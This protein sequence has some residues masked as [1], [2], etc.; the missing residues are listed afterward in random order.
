MTYSLDTVKGIKSSNVCEYWHM[1]NL[2]LFK[3]PSS[4]REMCATRG[5]SITSST[6][7]TS[8][9]SSTW[10]PKHTLVRSSCSTSA[11]TPLTNLVW[12]GRVKHTSA[13]L[14]CS[15]SSFESPSAFQ[16]VN[17][18][19]TRV[20]LQA[21]HGA[22][23]Q[24]Q[25]FVYV[26]TDEV[27]GGSVEEA[28]GWPVP[29]WNARSLARWITGSF[30]VLQVFDESSPVRPSNPYSATKAAAEYLV[31]SYWDKYKVRLSCS[32]SSCSLLWLSLTSK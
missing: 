8:T 15:E 28:S 1:S 17:V 19:G 4:N 24:P 23:H 10:R 21:A 14:L 3:F 29:R 22:P 16:R 12:H 9:W 7:K 31:R 18:D 25:C 11:F 20:L 30:G 6:Q 2:Q 5:W 26:S 27:Y 32:C 13:P